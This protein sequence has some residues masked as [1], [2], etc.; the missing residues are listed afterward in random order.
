VIC[1]NVNDLAFPYGPYFS[2]DAPNASAA[3]P[4]A[5]WDV[6]LLSAVLPPLL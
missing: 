2:A 3:L 5:S 4:A 6:M 1:V